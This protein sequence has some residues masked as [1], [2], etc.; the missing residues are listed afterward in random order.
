[1]VQV[2]TGSSKLTA[3]CTKKS[4]GRF[5]ADFTPSSQGQATVK[6]MYAGKEVTSS[7]VMFDT[8]VDPVKSEIRQVPKHVNVGEQATFTIQVKSTQ[9]HD[10][11]RGGEKFEVSVQGPENGVKGLVVRDENTGVYTVRFTLVTAGSFKFFITLRGSAL[12]GSPFVVV[13]Q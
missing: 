7:P 11:K 13:A 4:A 10:I 12:R 6:V 2:E 5:I 1:V 3:Y 8:G 9:A